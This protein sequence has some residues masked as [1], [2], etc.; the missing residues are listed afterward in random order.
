MGPKTNKISAPAVSYDE[1]NTMKEQM[2][3]VLASNETIKTRNEQLME[4]MQQQQP[5][6]NFMTLLSMKR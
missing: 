5:Q 4:Q 3:A 1:F 2:A 6:H